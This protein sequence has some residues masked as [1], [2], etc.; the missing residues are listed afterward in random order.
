[1][2]EDTDNSFS[3]RGIFKT[4]GPGILY[5][6]AAIGASHLV[7]STRAG[8][9]YGFDLLLL[10][11]L[12]NLF[13]Y[14]FFEYG[15]RFTAAT[16][17]SLIEGYRMLGKWAVTVFFVLSFATGIINFAAIA[18][19]TTGLG[20]HFLN[21][22]VNSI[23]LNIFV[24]LSLLLMLYIGK[25]S[26]LD[27]F[28]KFLI[29]ILSFATIIAFLYAY[30]NGGASHENFIKPELWDVA[31][32]SFLL[33]FMGWMPTPIEASAWTSLWTKEREKQTKYKPKFKE[34]MID[35][36][37]GYFCSTL[38]AMIFLGLGALVMFGSGD[39]FSDSSVKF[40]AQFVSLYSKQ[41]GSWSIPVISGIAFITIFTTALTVIDGYPR[42]LEASFIQIFDKL[43]KNSSKSY[44][45]WAIILSILASFIISMFAERMKLF[46]D[47]ATIVSFLAAPF[48]AII[49]Y[50]AVNASFVPKETQPK[51]WLKVLSWLGIIF[52]IGFGLVFI[53]ARIFL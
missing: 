14:P 18:L 3:K 10:L 11:I 12:V 4:L 40:S 37:I 33:A 29:A 48:F 20:A 26:F 17:K 15:H 52:L 36:H 41:F 13:K 6:G 23:W 46:L 53:Y 24:L 39:V 31:G 49:N 35:F 32:I 9:S 5:A 38:L 51:L 7:Q 2:T 22:D 1:M 45:F 30:I 8:A 16:G 27:S 19:V 28:M 25:Y 50:K 42:S 34:Y 47:F 44:W 21:I 43:K